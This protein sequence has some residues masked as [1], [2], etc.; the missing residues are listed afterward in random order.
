MTSPAWSHFTALAWL[1]WRAWVS[2]TGSAPPRPQTARPSG[3]LWRL[4]SA[5]HKS[6]ALRCSAAP[7][8]SR[9]LCR[10]RIVWP[11]RSGLLWEP[12]SAHAPSSVLG[13]DAG[14]ALVRTKLEGALGF[15]TSVLD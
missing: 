10:R 8:A 7:S 1:N 5:A 11:P 6:G 2:L 14:G 3:L 13:V 12:G 15:E 9:P 4:P